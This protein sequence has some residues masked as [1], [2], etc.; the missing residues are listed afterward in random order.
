MKK[1][2]IEIHLEPKEVAVLDKLAKEDK[3]SRKN[4]CETEIRKKIEAYQ[5]KLGS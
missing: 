5:L 3:R 2:R 4:Y 1:I